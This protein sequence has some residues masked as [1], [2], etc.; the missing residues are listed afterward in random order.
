MV[1]VAEVRRLRDEEGMSVQAALKHVTLCEHLEVVENATSVDELRP[2]LR[3][4]LA[5]TIGR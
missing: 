2:V 1:D 3:F 5:S 4:L